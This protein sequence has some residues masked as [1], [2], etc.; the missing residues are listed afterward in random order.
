VR[1]QEAPHKLT[2]SFAEFSDL[3]AGVSPCGPA[4]VRAQHAAPVPSV[5]AR[6]ISLSEAVRR[7][8]D[9]RLYREAAVPPYEERVRA[10]LAVCEK[11][12]DPSGDTQVAE[13]HDQHL[14]DAFAD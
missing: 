13:R 2:P 3:G 11:Y 4:H 14:A 1:R 5:R 6:G 9:E 7:C 10:A 12:R 8:V